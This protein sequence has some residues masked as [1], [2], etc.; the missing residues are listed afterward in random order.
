VGSPRRA[1]TGSVGTVAENITVSGKIPVVNVQNTRHQT[2]MR[3]DLLHAIP[4][5][6]NQ[7][8]TIHGGDANDRVW[9]SW[10]ENHRRRLGSVSATL[11]RVSA[12]H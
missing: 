6:L 10:D 12:R 4:R 5:P 3:R 11:R 2:V 7:Q 1:A 9:A 8:L